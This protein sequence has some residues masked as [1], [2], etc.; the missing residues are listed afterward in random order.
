MTPKTKNA[1]G[2]MPING[3]LLDHSV[4][5]TTPSAARD[6][7]NAKPVIPNWRQK[8]RGPQ[9]TITDEDLED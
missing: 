9:I 6:A 1:F 8:K 2:P 4:T 3:K 7:P 5:D